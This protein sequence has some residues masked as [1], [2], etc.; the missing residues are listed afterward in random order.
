M[1]AVGGCDIRIAT[2]GEIDEMMGV[3]GFEAERGFIGPKGLK[4]YNGYEIE[5]VADETVKELKN[6]VEA[7]GMLTDLNFEDYH[8]KDLAD[9][10]GVKELENVKENFVT[11]H[12]ISYHS[13]KLVNLTKIWNDQKI[14][15]NLE[16]LILDMAR[17]ISKYFQNDIVEHPNTLMWGRKPECWE[18]VK[19]LTYNIA[20]LDTEQPFEFMPSNPVNKF[21]DKIPPVNGE[22]SMEVK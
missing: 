21:I 9:Q 13:H 5:I 14:D 8:Y 6:F 16:F 22:D 18:I 2:A 17:Q 15:S 4:E 19:G 11:L 1:N 7:C 12:F 20:E 10:L 3:N